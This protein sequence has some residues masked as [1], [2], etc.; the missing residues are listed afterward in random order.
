MTTWAGFGEGTFHDPDRYVR[1]G[2]EKDDPRPVIRTQGGLNH[3][4]ETHKIGPMP[5]WMAQVLEDWGIPPELM[6][7]GRSEAATE[8]MMAEPY[9]GKPYMCATCGREYALF[10]NASAC[11]RN[12]HCQDSPTK[13]ATWGG[14]TTVPDIEDSPEVTEALK[15]MYPEE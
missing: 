7:T 2:L 8:A 6:N 4:I 12:G 11:E 10:V 15:I 9:Q 5:D 3:F 1:E 14:P 13:K